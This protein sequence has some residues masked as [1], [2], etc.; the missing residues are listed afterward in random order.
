M[1]ELSKLEVWELAKQNGLVNA[2]GGVDQFYAIYEFVK[3]IYKKA[4]EE[5]VKD[6]LKN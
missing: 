2:N 1:K 3:T 6:L 4:Q 5:C